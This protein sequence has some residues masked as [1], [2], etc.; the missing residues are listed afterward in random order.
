[1][2]VDTA[3]GGVV[4]HLAVSRGFPTCGSIIQG[5]NLSDDSRRRTSRITHH[6]SETS[7]VLYIDGLGPQQIKIKKP[8][9]CPEVDLGLAPNFCLQQILVLVV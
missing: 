9:F 3:A 5:P 7:S 8:Y 1:M 2:I 6:C 4:G